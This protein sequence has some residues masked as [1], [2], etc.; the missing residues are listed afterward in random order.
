MLVA[1]DSPRPK[2]LIVEDNY[3][4]AEAVGDLVRKCGCE[5]AG[6]VGRV[7]SGVEF[8][9]TNHV[10]AAVVDIDLRG[11]ASFPIC[12]QLSK[13]DIPFLFLSG[14]DKNYA[15]PPEFQG[16]VRLSKPV[17][18]RELEKA[19]AA[20]AFV[21]PTP[22]VERGNFVLDR[23]PL[24]TWRLLQPRLQQVAMA[25]EEM[26][27][28]PE[29]ETSHVYFPVTGLVSI[30]A[31]SAQGKR[32]EVALVGR[33]GLTG[34]AA[35]LGRTS[36]RGTEAVVQH[37][38]LAW[39]IPVPALTELRRLDHEFDA[40]LLRAVDSL[41]CQLARNA[42]ATGYGTIEQRLA[43]RLLMTSI[44]LGTRRI[45]LTHDGLAKVL[46]V[47]RSGITVALHMLESRQ[48]IR[49]RRN[50]IE[51]LDFGALARAAGQNCWTAADFKFA[52]DDQG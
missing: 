40:Q 2:I 13:R 26:L 50:L 48:M 17:D 36:A 5:V 16:A 8:L 3:L 22:S 35:L 46:A 44:R 1:Q 39:R 10:D 51:I 43:R 49:G 25:G 6:A 38:G 9:R 19:L 33:D 42:L 15:I 47:R 28:T 4:T 32:I 30:R 18:G 23:L 52:A 20:L 24:A 37:P 12:A 34:I 21:V 27:E 14:Y 29:G 11:T 45:A 31:C 41:I 7:E